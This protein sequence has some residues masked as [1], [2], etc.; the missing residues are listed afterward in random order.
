MRPSPQ[1]G[2]VA[3]AADWVCTVYASDPSKTTYQGH[4]SI[5]GEGSQFCSGSGWENTAI[6]ITIQRYA[7]VGIWNN[8]YQWTSPW[9]GV[10]EGDWI[11]EFIYYYCSGSGT[12]TYRV[13]TD[14]WA[15]SGWY[16]DSVQSL[17]YLRV[18]C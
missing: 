6:R 10:P 13:V 14:G 11:D 16:T 9:E 8:K 5:E 4:A 2:K 3:P 15:V 17:N 7:G 1:P 18:S 12:Q